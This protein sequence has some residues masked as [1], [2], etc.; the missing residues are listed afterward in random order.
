MEGAFTPPTAA[1]LGETAAPGRP[2]LRWSSRTRSIDGVAKELAKIWSSVS[3]TTPGEEGD[4]ERRVAAR[5]SVMNLVV[6]AG[7]GE[8][9]ERA[10][11]IVEGLTGRHPSRTL[12]VS[13]ADPDGPS[14]LDAQVQA[15][16]M[17]PSAT[18]P[19][20]CSE[21]VYVT[22]GG[23]SGQHMAGIVAPLLI[24]DLP[25]TLWWPGEPHF[26]SRSVKDWLTMADRVIVDGAGWS[27]DGLAGLVAMS[28]L[29]KRFQVEISDFA[30][31]RQARWREAIASTFDRP[32]LLPCLTSIDRIELCYAARDGIAGHDQ[33]RPARL[34]RRLAGI[35]ARDGRGLADHRRHGA[36]ERLHGPAAPRPTPGAR[37][38][39]PGRIIVAT[40]H[41]VV[42]RGPRDPQPS[43]ALDRRDR[44][45]GRRGRPRLVR[46]RRHAGADV[47]CASAARIGPPGADDRFRRPGPDRGRGHRQGGR[48]DPAMNVDVRGE[49]RIEVL[50]D[51][52]ACSDAAAHAIA[53]ALAD[54]V[55]RRGRADWATTG[56]ST[57]VGIYQVLATAPH[58]DE[59]PWADVQIWWGDDR[60]VPRDH[61]LSNVL[62]LDQVLLSASARAG[63]SGTGADAADVELGVEPGIWLPPAHVHAPPMTRAIADGSG[64]EGAVAAYDAE[65]R[66]GGPPTGESGVPAFDVVLLGIGPDGHVLS[67]FPG[68]PLLDDT[69]AWVAAVPA[70]THVEPHVPRLT[71]TPRIL[72]AAG[73]VVVVVHGA[74]KAAILASVLGPERDE[75]RWPAQLARGENATWFLDRAAAA[76][77]PAPPA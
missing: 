55:D 7:R 35:P 24:H 29:P 46:R 19:E 3:L 75:R 15:H 11:A 61:P 64:L 21:L 76:E 2:I 69:E 18:A 60:F 52:A 39:P 57:P 23:E 27:G 17:L 59:V 44:V 73:S 63:L 36:L 77:L 72:D 20:T 45:R 54:A 48:A 9:G 13:P 30:L 47:L 34:P 50:D 58:R 25:V 5:S 28:S 49:P 12:I 14:W 32:A 6:I 38:D 70:P 62:P 37:R 53:R 10:A 43:G 74:G 68:S 22:C 41:D 4:A 42:R 66:A 40:R 33:R 1:P 56:G 8:V 51:P 71:L 26:E 16:C 31:I 65:L 67:V